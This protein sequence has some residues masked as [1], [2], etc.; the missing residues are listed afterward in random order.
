MNYTIININNIKKN[1]IT[2]IKKQLTFEPIIKILGSERH[3]YPFAFLIT[4]G[5]TICG[6]FYISDSQSYQHNIDEFPLYERALL[7]QKV[8]ALLKTDS[9]FK[10][11]INL[12]EW[13]QPFLEKDSYNRKEY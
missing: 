13:E 1:K 3:S 4:K 8:I 5:E 2:L 7:C 11:I 12:L 9:K 6:F 10:E